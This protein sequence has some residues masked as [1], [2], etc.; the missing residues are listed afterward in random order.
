MIPQQ[1]WIPSVVGNL[2]EYLVQELRRAQYE[3]APLDEQWIKFQKIYR[4]RPEHQEK[5]FPWPGASNVVIPLAATDIDTVTARILGILFSQQG[6]WS[7]QALRP[8]FV[9][10]APKL[11]EFLGWAQDAELNAYDSISDFVL[12][13]AKL[14]TG[15]LKQRYVREQRKVYEFRET[16]FGTMER[17]TRQFIKDHPEMN[18]VALPDFWVPSSARDIQNAAWAGERIELSWDQL[19]TRER[20]GIYQGIDR[21]ASWNRTAVTR[22]SQY[23]NAQEA[24]DNFLP[25]RGDRFELYEFWLDY[26]IDR[27]TE[28]EACVVTLHEPTMTPLRIDFNPFFHQEKPYSFARYIRQEGRFYG[29][30][31]AEI[32]EHFQHEATTMHNQRI[33]NNTVLNTSAFRAKRGSVKQ[34]QRIWPGAFIYMDDPQNDIVPFFMGQKADST[35]QAEDLLL[36][37]AV[38]R[39]GVNDWVNPA[40]NPSANYSTATTAVQML[41]EG[42]KRFDQTMREIR[43][44]I[45]ESGTRNVELYQQFNQGGKPYMVL[46]DEDGSVVAQILQFPTQAIRTGVFIDVMAT[47]AQVNKETEARTNQMIFGLVMQFYQQMMQGV[48]IIANPQL[49]PLMRQMA[50]LM[51]DGGTKLARRI[52]DAYGTQDT[53]SIIPDLSNAVNQLAAQLGAVQNP[54]MGGPPGY[55]GAPGAPGLPTVSEGAPGAFNGFLPGAPVFGGVTNY[56]PRAG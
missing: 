32:L 10:F 30:G 5:M 46:G 2:V 3:R 49:P 7:V 42:A 6:L 51:V 37:Y 33:D 41:R 24:L 23:R 15:I 29:I 34:D 55:P 40:N 26:D 14:G 44:A 17:M 25:S 43:R 4:A 16:P 50:A 8:D 54:G 9:D 21:I 13:V 36:N 39:T 12:D 28:P 20:A 52:L 35:I 18:R 45:S 56:L 47:N 48:A 31:L 11:E 27:D 53:D 1:L 19:E 38:R 22:G